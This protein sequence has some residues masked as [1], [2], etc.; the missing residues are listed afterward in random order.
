MDSTSKPVAV[1][2]GFVDFNTLRYYALVVDT[3]LG[4]ALG[5]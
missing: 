5:P 4:A 3:H 2:T 1:I